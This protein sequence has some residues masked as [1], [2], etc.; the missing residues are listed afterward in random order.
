RGAPP[1]PGHRADAEVLI[2]AVSWT[3]PECGVEYDSISPQDAVQALRSFPRRYREVIGPFI[4]DEDVLRRRPDTRTWSALEYTAHVADAFESLTPD[5]VK[6][7]EQDN[8][9]L[10]DPWD[11]DERARDRRYNDMDPREALDWLERAAT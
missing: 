4:D 5:L 11:P 7:V 10:P 1:P 2:V 8:P 6:I 9:R 3:C